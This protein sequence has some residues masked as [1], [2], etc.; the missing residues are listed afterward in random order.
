MNNKNPNNMIFKRKILPKLLDNIE[1]NKIIILTGPRQVG[2]T[3][4]LKMIY[5]KIA[6]KS[7]AIFL[8]MDLTANQEFGKDLSKFI[9]Y[10]NLNGYSQK[11]ERFYVFVDEFQRLPEMTMVFKNIYDNYPNIKIFASGSSSLSIKKSAKESLAGRK[12]IFEIFPLDFEEFLDFKEDE[13]AKRYFRNINNLQEGKITL[14]QKLQELREEFFVFGGYPEVVLQN[15]YQEKKKILK[16]IFDLYAEKDAMLFLG[17]ENIWAY[18]KIIQLLAVDSGSLLNY[19]NLAKESGIHNETVRSYISMLEETYLIKILRPF[20][21]NKHNEIIKSP[22]VY[23]LDNGVR[24]YFLNN[25]NKLGKRVDKG[26]IFESYILQEI[27][28]NNTRNCNVKF[29]RTKQKDEV[30]FVLEKENG[31]F[32]VEAKFSSLGKVDD[33][34]TVQKFLFQYDQESGYV[35]NGNFK[36]LAEKDGK[37]IM[38]DVAINFAQKLLK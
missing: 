7:K 4:L 28:K 23:F 38:F 35:L 1:N 36:K 10:L 3:T 2:K 37:K 25:F 34:R 24:N 29:W 5:A 9:S 17:V 33:M 20:S 8:D 30:D 32:P 22:K 6:Q 26:S 14:P 31:I 27:V 13:E 18:K 16:S 19:N 15:D 21:A 12:F 11:E